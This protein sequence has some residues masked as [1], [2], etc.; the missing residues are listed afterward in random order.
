MERLTNSYKDLMAQVQQELQTVKLSNNEHLL[1]SYLEL[2]WFPGGQFCVTVILATES[3]RVRMVKQSW[4]NKYDLDRFSSGVYNLDRLCI[5]K[6][7]IELSSSHQ[8][9]LTNIIDS[10]VEFPDTLEDKE[11]ILLDGIEYQLI[12]NA[13]NAGRIYQWRMPTKDISNF[14]PLINFLLT[15][16]FEE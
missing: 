8:E 2:P 16:T 4:D 7:E 1:V 6:A 11:Y 14:E 15:V 10:I 9:V 13:K 5:K 3:N 12:F